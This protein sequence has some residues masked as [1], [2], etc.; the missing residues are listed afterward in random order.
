M[1]PDPTIEPPEGSARSAAQSAVRVSL[2]GRLL[3]TALKL[4]V[5]RALARRGISEL[6]AMR[7]RL[8]HLADRLKFPSTVVRS[9]ALLGAISAEW[10]RVAGVSDPARI[11]FYCHGG[12]YLLGSARMYR[13]LTYQ[14]A[15]VCAA[16]VVAI[17]YR[18]APE[19]PYPA[20]PDDAL[21]AYRALLNTGVQAQR[22]VV[23]GDSAGGNLALVLLQRLRAAR[24]PLPAAAVLF[25]PWADLTGSGGSIRTRAHLDPMLPANR[26]GEAAAY[27]APG[28]DL[29]NSDIS[30]VFGDF[31]SMP[32]LLVHVGS[33][34]ILLDDARRV[35]AAARA[36]KVDVSYREWTGMPHVFQAFARFVPEARMALEEVG[37]FVIARVSAAR[38]A[39]LDAERAAN[40]VRLRSA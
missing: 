30:P 2:R 8:D 38:A 24:L 33:R 19:H 16:E 20:A 25:S 23:A 13:D 22:I 15:K 40:V 6:S 39:A 34:E 17:D 27:Y 3:S 7:E 31:A 1:P 36:T 37:A 32:P 4:T 11:V 5:K 28:H 12:A 18:L 35:V 9:T 29:A 26:I 21:A 14:L 10:T